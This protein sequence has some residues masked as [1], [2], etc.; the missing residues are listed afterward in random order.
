M[1][2]VI[3]TTTSRQ[4]TKKNNLYVCSVLILYDFT[5]FFVCN[6]VKK[7]KESKVIPVTVRLP[8]FFGSN[9]GHIFEII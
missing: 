2:S 1:F 8:Y 3:C 5:P 6:N 9:P 4:A 7:A